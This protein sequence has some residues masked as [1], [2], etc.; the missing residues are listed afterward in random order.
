MA[1][2]GRIRYVEIPFGGV[3][4]TG[5]LENPFQSSFDDAKWDGRLRAKA[6]RLVIEDDEFEERCKVDL[7]LQKFEPNSWKCVVVGKSKG[8]NQ[9]GDMNQYVLLV[10]ERL[11]SVVPPV[12]ERVGVGILLQT[13]V[14][15]ETTI[16]HIA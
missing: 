6:R 9:E 1:L 3:T 7:S 14:A 16:F 13:H 12:Y 5:D 10:H 2:M 15:L 8:A 11:S 4:W